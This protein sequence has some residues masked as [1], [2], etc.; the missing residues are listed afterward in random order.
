MKKANKLASREENRYENGWYI[1]PGCKDYAELKAMRARMGLSTLPSKRT[2]PDFNNR[3][4]L[5]YE[6]NKYIDAMSTD[7]G[8]PLYMGNQGSRQKG[9]L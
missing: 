5:D 1:P 3:R 8:W 2:R 7:I 6:D 4:K 9:K